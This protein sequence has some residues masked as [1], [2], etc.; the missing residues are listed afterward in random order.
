MADNDLNPIRP[1]E[2]LQNVSSLT[3]TS[4][5]QQSKRR[6]TPSRPGRQPPGTPSEKPAEEQLSGHDNDAHTIDYRA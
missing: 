6:P 5:R 3:P 4:S 1:V 2:N